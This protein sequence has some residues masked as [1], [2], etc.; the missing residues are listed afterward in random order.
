MMRLYVEH[1]NSGNVKTH[2]NSSV[3]WIKD[4]GPIVESYIGFIET[5]LDPLHRRAEFES[6]VAFVN[7][8][9]SKV[10]EDLVTHAEKFI[11]HL[12]WGKDFECDEFSKPDYTTLDVLTF[13]TSGTPLGINIPNYDDIR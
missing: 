13:A 6:W 1:F 8:K 7:K 4:K 12:P 10:F 2:K 11:P 5:Y 9:E 3:A